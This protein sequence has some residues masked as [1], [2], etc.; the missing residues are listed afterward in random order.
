MQNYL[1]FQKQK[2]LRIIV[3]PSPHLGSGLEM[4][5]D[6]I[7]L[8]WTT[9]Q[10]VL[11]T[12]LHSFSNHFC[13][14]CIFLSNSHSVEHDLFSSKPNLL[15][16]IETQVTGL[17]TR[18]SILISTFSVLNFVSRIIKFMKF[19]PV[20]KKWQVSTLISTK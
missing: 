14:I 1:K 16:P 11:I 20:R 3:P 7:P 5:L 2:W 17:L 19:T 9:L 10:C 12:P 15:S 4:S 18:T 13:K 8:H 6:H